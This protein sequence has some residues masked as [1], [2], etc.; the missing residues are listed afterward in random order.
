MTLGWENATVNETAN[1]TIG[2][3]EGL[4][5]DTIGNQMIGSYEM[6]GLIVLAIFVVVLWRSN[7]SLDTSAVFM[8]P[9][10]FIVGK[11]GLL[12]GGG[13]T[14]YGMTVAIGG[15]LAYGFY[16]YFR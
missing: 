9:A 7:V 14:L 1:Q 12:P 13:S 8:I 2:D 5:G 4:I 11:L 3:L 10:L 6:T 15:L 16:R